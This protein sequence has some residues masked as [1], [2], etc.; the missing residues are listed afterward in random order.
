MQPVQLSDGKSIGNIIVDK[1]NHVLARSLVSRNIL[2]NMI[3]KEERTPLLLAV[4]KNDIEMIRIL[5]DQSNLSILGYNNVILHAAIK[6]QNKKLIKQ[7]AQQNKELVHVANDEG[8]TPL[9]LTAL[10]NYTAS[11]VLLLPYNPQINACDSNGSTA[12]SL[13]AEQ[14]HSAMVRLLLQQ[15]DI[16]ADV[17]DNKQETSLIKASARGHSKVEAMLLSHGADR[18]IQE[19]QGNTALHK[20]A[21]E[22]HL[23]IAK[24]LVDSQH[25][26]LV[27]K[28]NNDG[29]L[30]IRKAAQHNQELVLTFLIEHNSPI[31][32][33]NNRG[34]SPLHCASQK[35]NEVVVRKLLGQGASR[36]LLTKKDN[37]ALHIALLNKHVTVAHFLTDDIIINVENRDGN[38]PLASS[39]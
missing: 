8:Q 14:G 30:A 31:N 26:Y 11:A 22:G 35:G 29:D 19:Q 7:L 16:M 24:N 20:A 10:H 18:R 17:P 23:A 1:K 37:S 28:K 6:Q 39:E 9:M 38:T 25:N 34:F 3:D 2:L 15:S 13:A 36:L 5:I 4:E 27:A 21:Q 12:L 32:Q 33:Q